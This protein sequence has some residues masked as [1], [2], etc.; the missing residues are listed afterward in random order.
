MDIIE[1]V[2]TKCEHSEGGGLLKSALLTLKVSGLRVTSARKLILG[3]LTK[4]H[5]PFTS[6][7]IHAGIR[8]KSCDLVTVYRTLSTLEEIGLVRKYDVGDRVAR[9]E[10]LCAVHPHHHL[11]CKSCKKIE[12]LHSSLL[13]EVRKVAS[14]KGFATLSPSIDVFGVCK[15]CDLR[16]LARSVCG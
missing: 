9:F 2:K 14:R 10:F 11:I 1:S 5:G 13:D 4:A 16:K 15:S 3:F 12:V 8:S 6:E 7:E